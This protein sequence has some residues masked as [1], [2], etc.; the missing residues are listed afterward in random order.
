MVCRRFSF[1]GLATGVSIGGEPACYIIENH[2]S[3]FVEGQVCMC[4]CVTEW[5]VRD[6]TKNCGMPWSGMLALACFILPFQ[7]PC[8]VEL[9]WDQMYRSTLHYG[10][11]G[12]PM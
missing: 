9:I 5:E 2:L 10:R 12:L 4:M 8:N 6:P 1:L 11:K 3:R 7:D